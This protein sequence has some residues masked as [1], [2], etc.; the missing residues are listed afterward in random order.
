MEIPESDMQTPCYGCG[1]K[2]LNIIS[3]INKGNA[4]PE[5]PINQSIHLDCYIKLLVEKHLI[6]ML[7]L[8]FQSGKCMDEGVDPPIGKIPPPEEIA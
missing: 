7:N 6:R 5:I 4:V 2:K 3:F 8:T 1:S